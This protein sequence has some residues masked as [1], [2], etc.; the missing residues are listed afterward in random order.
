MAKRDQ[1]LILKQLDIIMETVH[2][3]REYEAVDMAI[4]ML[5]PFEKLRCKRVK[6]V[7]EGQIERLLEYA[8]KPVNYTDHEQVV[9]QLATLKGY[10]QGVMQD[11]TV[12]ADDYAEELMRRDNG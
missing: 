11:L 4:R 12:V 10:V 1:G 7:S 3:Q 9:N 6:I 5:R 2:T 8:I